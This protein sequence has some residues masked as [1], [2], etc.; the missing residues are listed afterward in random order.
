[1]NLCHGLEYPEPHMEQNKPEKI[2][3]TDYWWKR[4]KAAEELLGKIKWEAAQD[5]EQE[6]KLTLEII[7]EMLKDVEVVKPKRNKNSETIG[8]SG[9]N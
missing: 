6:W 9:A 5:S 8:L 2:N 4:A 1:M 3:S 7:Q